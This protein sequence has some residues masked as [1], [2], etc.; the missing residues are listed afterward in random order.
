MATLKLSLCFYTP[1]KLQGNAPLYKIPLTFK[2]KKSGGCTKK[3]SNI[4]SKF[5]TRWA[6][7]ILFLHSLPFLSRFYSLFWKSFIKLSHLQGFISALDFFRIRHSAYKNQTVKARFIDYS[8]TTP[9]KTRRRFVVEPYIF[10]KSELS[11]YIHRFRINVPLIN[12]D[13]LWTSQLPQ[14]MTV[15][16]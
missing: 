13:S 14:L 12:A 5:T 1:K 11:S 10:W 9:T 3:L 4:Y 15:G 2:G 6:K 16:M 7:I 8:C